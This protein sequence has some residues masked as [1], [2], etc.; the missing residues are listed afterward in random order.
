MMDIMDVAALKAEACRV[1]AENEFANIA[2]A[3]EKEGIPISELA[4]FE[5]SFKALL[6]NEL[7]RTPSWLPLDFQSEE[8][9]RAWL[10]SGEYKAAI[11]EIVVRVL[12]S[13]E[14]G[15]KGA[16][17]LDFTVSGRQ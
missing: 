10:E 16:T 11:K 14:Y 7:A 15:G 1:I 4:E 12:K 8:E 17:L 9:L 5:K 6:Q 2:G 3:V 13:I